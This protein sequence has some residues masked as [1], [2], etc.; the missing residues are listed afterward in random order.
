MSWTG[1]PI[2]SGAPACVLCGRPTF[3][4]G[5]REGPWVRAVVRGRQVLVCPS[6]AGS[7]PEW[8][9]MVD[10]CRACGGTRLS[11]TLGRVVC[12]ACGHEQDG[13]VDAG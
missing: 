6:C 2:P 5:R 3:D 8:I 1:P 12:R 4:P 7:R 9:A 10:R 13:V 11:V